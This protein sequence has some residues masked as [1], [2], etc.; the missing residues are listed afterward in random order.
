MAIDNPEVSYTKLLSA[1][2]TI[3]ILQYLFGLNAVYQQITA[4][5]PQKSPFNS[6]LTEFNLSNG[7]ATGH[8]HYLSANYDKD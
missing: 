1:R 7:Y 3:T 5:Y 6:G 4:F 8:F 2:H